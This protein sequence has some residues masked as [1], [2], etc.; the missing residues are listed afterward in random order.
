L[1]IEISIRKPLLYISDGHMLKP[2]AQL[3]TCTEMTVPI[4]RVPRKPARSKA[5]FL[6]PSTAAVIVLPTHFQNG[7]G[8]SSRLRFVDRYVYVPKQKKS[9]PDCE[10]AAFK[11]GKRRFEAMECKMTSL[12]PP[13]APPKA[14]H[15]VVGS[16]R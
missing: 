16:C 7:R 3:V 5:L 14:P 11:G 15:R 13:T 9:L 1:Y 2:A 10:R 12:N 4:T 8:G 6:A